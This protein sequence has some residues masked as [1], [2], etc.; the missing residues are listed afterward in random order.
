HGSDGRGRTQSELAFQT[1]VP[2]FTDCDF[3]VRE[4]NSDW[5]AI[6]H[7]G[8]PARGF[9][10]LMPAFSEA[11]STDEID[12][13]LS[14]LRAFCPDDRWPRGELNMPRALFTE[15]AF[16]EDEAVITTTVVSEGPDSLSHKFLWEQRFG[17]LNQI[18]ISVPIT[19]AD[20]GD[21]QGWESG[22]GDLAI[23]VK[24][25]LRHSFERGSILSVGGEL[26]LPTGDEAKG[27]GKGTT[28][29]ESFIMFGKLLPRD[30]FLQIQGIAEFPTDDALEDEIAVRAAL[31]RTW[32]TG[33]PFGR[34]W[35]PIVEILG[36]RALDG[37]ADTQWDLVPQFQV[38]LNARQHLMANAGLRLP[39]T[40]RSERETE[41]VFYLLWDWFDGGVLEGW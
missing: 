32:T 3:A 4:P 6:V 25:T 37:G 33:G 13:V 39:V 9:N 10:R 35:T 17:P 34:A 41:L 21:P 27:F 19:R 36:A 14:H 29:F 5:S 31:G 8:G 1:P 11:L 12:Q 20:L 22:T 30:A 7:N 38:T 40:Q 23:G 16:P 26:V 18:E 15:K 2:N 28:V 24:H